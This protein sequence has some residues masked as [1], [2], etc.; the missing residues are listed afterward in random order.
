MV[1]TIKMTY[2]PNFS[3]I[4]ISEA[5]ET[6]T[7]QFMNPLPSPMLKGTPVR[8]DVNGNLQLVSPSNEAD[9]TAI[10]GLVDA[11]ILPGATGDVANSGR[12]ENIATTAPLGSSMYLDING[13]ITD[14][15]P[16]VGVGGFNAGDFVVFLGV[17]AKNRQNPNNKDLLVRIQL[18]G[19]L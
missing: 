5:A 1:G 4:S 7:N 14:T 19:Q 13:S 2:N 9:V 10:A 18:I 16:S 8:L 6:T 17:I 3:S 11:D 12:L 15:K